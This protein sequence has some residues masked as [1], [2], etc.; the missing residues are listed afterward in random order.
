M[1][2]DLRDYRLGNTRFVYAPRGES[3]GQSRNVEDGHIVFLVQ[4]KADTMFLCQKLLGGFFSGVRF[5]AALKD[6]H[7][8]NFFGA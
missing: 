8:C 6:S 4:L 3:T 2:A 7:H 1:I 5:E